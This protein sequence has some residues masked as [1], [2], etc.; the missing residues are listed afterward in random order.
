METE[1]SK[2]KYI[3]KIIEGNKSEFLPINSEEALNNIYHLFRTGEELKITEPIEYLYYGWYFSFIKQDVLKMKYYYKAGVNKNYMHCM[4]NLSLYYKSKKKYNKYLKYAKMGAEAGI[5]S[6]YTDMGDYYRGISDF[7]KMK[8]NYEKAIDQKATSAMIN[9]AEYLE[10]E[11]KENAK[12]YLE[13]A[14]KE[15]SDYAK[16]KLAVFYRDS[17]DY[18]S[19]KTLLEG[20]ENVNSFYILGDYYL[21]CERNYKLAKEYLLKCA[22][23]GIVKA[24]LDISYYFRHVERDFQETEKYLL[25]GCKLKS[26]KA[27]VELGHLYQYVIG[28]K[29]DA[30][31]YYQMAIDTDQN[32][33]AMI[34]MIVYY[35]TEEQDYEKMRLYCD[36]IIENV[37]SSFKSKLASMNVVLNYCKNEK[38]EAEYK[39]KMSDLLHKEYPSTSLDLVTKKIG[40]YLPTMEDDFILYGNIFNEMMT[41]PNLNSSPYSLFESNPYGNMLNKMLKKNLSKYSTYG[42]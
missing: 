41:K 5:V 15:G 14:V 27:M 3:K 4:G 13:I 32:E 11:D 38:L 21:K 28:N 7:D 40:P 23:L 30:V 25:M 29:K 1:I 9:Y 39:E 24:I 12:K 33:N 10:K 37:S 16:I 20:M 17:G 26:S 8:E 42:F 36:M 6:L 31:K 35:E 18:Q 19:M 2:N 34:N 22:N